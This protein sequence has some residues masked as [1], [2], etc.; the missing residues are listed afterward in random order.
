MLS[1]GNDEFKDKH[2]Y[3]CCERW[4]ALMEN[5]TT[6]GVDIGNLS[7]RLRFNP[8]DGCIWLEGERVVM[9]HLAAFANLRRELIDTFGI[10]VARGLLTRM[11][12]TSGAADA[13]LARRT[14][15]HAGFR[16]SFMAG[17][18]LHAIEG[19]VAVDP[20]L[21]DADPETGFHGGEWIWRNSAEV[22]AHLQSYGMSAEPVCWA[23]TGYASAYTSAFMG[24]PILFR[25][26]ECRA[27]GARHCRIVAKPS[28]QWDDQARDDLHQGF[29]LEDT[30]AEI[31][32][33]WASICGEPGYEAARPSDRLIGASAGFVSIMHMVDKVA[34]TDAAVILIGEPGVGKKSC[35]RVL[36]KLSA[37]GTKPFV[38]FNC[39]ALSG[40]Q[41]DAELFGIEKSSS[42]GGSQMGRTGRVE[43][44]NGGTLFLEDV[45]RLDLRAQTKLLRMLQTGEIE[46]VGCSQ[47]RAVRIR[48]IAAS[49]ARLVEA[50]RDGSFREDLYYRLTTFPILIPP[51]RE[52]RTDLPLLIRH[53]LEVFAR[54]YGKEITGISEMAV[55]YLLT[56]D[57][58]GNV[59]ELESMIERAVIMAPDKGPLGVTYLGSPI[60]ERNP[61]F[62]GL[63]TRGLL[64][65]KADDGGARHDL[66]ALDRLLDSNFELETFENELIARAVERASGNLSKA[67]KSLGLTRPQ[68]AYR[69]RKIQDSPPAGLDE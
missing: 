44:A 51:L 15:P 55:G 68:L 9:L 53:F 7:A 18:R 1:G 61:R 58:P 65:S 23:L 54:R 33:G 43:R 22:D 69:Y 62:Y 12:H 2:R 14:M 26:V 40:D 8:Q 59:T 6:V 25:E 5:E 66:G 48:L 21:F 36:H 57:F 34:R 30:Q 42:A 4:R 17:P 50:V 24:S 67:A 47:P 41:L 38:A 29:D 31:G 19:M 28:D 39:A 56:Y 10:D 20:V 45:H 11:G 13:A 37:R 52:R 16:E 64:I 63:S 35:A 27:M 32:S 46:R 3:G 60:D 49:N